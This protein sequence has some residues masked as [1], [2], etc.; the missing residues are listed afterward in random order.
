MNKFNYCVHRFCR[1][2]GPNRPQTETVPRELICCAE[3]LIPHLLKAFIRAV[4]LSFQSG[5]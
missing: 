2:H 5:K 1:F 3:L 4:R